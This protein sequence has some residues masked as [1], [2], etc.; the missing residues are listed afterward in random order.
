M[1]PFSARL[2]SIDLRAT[3][4]ALGEELIH[5]P[6]EFFE[7]IH[8]FHETRGGTVIRDVLNLKLSRAYGGN[9][10]ARVCSL[11]RRWTRAFLI[12]R[13]RLQEIATST[14]TAQNDDPSSVTL[15][16]MEMPTYLLFV[17]GILGAID[18]AVYRLRAFHAAAQRL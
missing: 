15:D 4:G 14:P 10:M 16:P 5:G 9:L 7:H 11:A 17:L 2:S 12:R 18:I 8:E 3:Y 13:R 1:R 6:F